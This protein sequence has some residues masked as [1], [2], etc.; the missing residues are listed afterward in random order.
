MKWTGPQ[1]FL[2]FLLA[3]TFTASTVAAN[4]LVS[5]TTGGA[6]IG[7]AACADTYFVTQ[8]LNAQ[9]NTNLYLKDGQLGGTAAP[10]AY[11]P[12]ASLRLTELGLDLLKGNGTYHRPQANS[13]LDFR[14][15]LYAGS[16]ADALK[17]Y[18]TDAIREFT[19][20]IGKLLN[21]EE[22]FRQ[23]LKV[24]P[25]WDQALDGLMETYYARAEGFMLIGNDFLARAY[26]HKFERKS[27]ES[28][29]TTEL[30]IQDIDNALQ[31]Y[32][33]GFR[34]FMKLFNP[35]YIG[36]D[37]LPRS[38]LQINAE[39]LLFSKRFPRQ[40]SSDLVSYAAL[41]G[42]ETEI[43]VTTELYDPHGQV[44]SPV[45]GSPSLAFEESQ[46]K[47]IVAIQAPVVFTLPKYE[48]M[49]SSGPG[50]SFVLR[51][52]MDVAT[53]HS[54]KDLELL[55]EF[56]NETL[57]PPSAFSDFSF[58]NSHLSLIPGT[59]VFYG[60]SSI[61][62][63]KQLFANQ[64]LL[65]FSIVT[66]A[67]G[68][69]IRVVSVPFT[70]RADASR[71]TEV[72]VYVAGSG[73]QLV[74]GFK[75]IALLYRI[76]AAYGDALGEKVRRMYDIASPQQAIKALEDAIYRINQWFEL[77]Q[78]M[79]E[80]ASSQA[81][82]A[83]NDRL[84]NAIA[85]VSSE[86]NE[87]GALREFIRS[88]ANAFGYPDDYVPFFNDDSSGTISALRNLI[89]GPGSFTPGSAT[90]FFGTARDAETSSIRSYGQLQDTK[91]RIRNELFTINEQAESRLLQICGRIDE[92]TLDPSMDSSDPIDVD[93]RA[94]GKNIASEFGQHVLLFQRA[95]SALEQANA[96]MDRLLADIELEK[97]FLA[98]ALH[99]HAEKV[100]VMNEYSVL[101]QNLD[102]E[103]GKINAKQARL[104]AVTQAAQTM[105]AG[106]NGFSAITGGTHAATV[107][108]A[109]ALANGMEQAR[110]EER[111]GELQADKTR[112]AA[113]E[114]IK[115]IKSDT[116]IFELQQVKT[117][118][119]LA[120]QLVLKA[121][122]AEM[123]ELDLQVALGRMNQLM[124]ERDELL[125]RRGRAITN[126]GEMSFAD[127]SFRLIQFSVMKDAED[128]VE[129][130]KR[131]LYLLTRTVYYEWA[132]ADDTKLRVAGLPDISINDIRRLQVIGAVNEGSGVAALEDSLTVTDYLQTLLAFHDSGPLRYSKSP[133]TINRTNSSNTARYS[134]REDFLRIVRE[135]NTL[136]ENQR[137]WKEFSAWLADPAR[138]DADGNLVIE[139][140]TMGHLENHNLP[141]DINH[142]SWTHYA[143]R[144]YSTSPLWNHKITQV[145]VSLQPRG[146]AFVSGVLNVT[147]SLQYGGVGYLKQ[148]SDSCSDF[149]AYQMR[150]WRDKGNGR[151]EPIDYRTIP[152]SIPDSS[153]FELNEAAYLVNSLKERP[154]AA[155]S[156]RLV[157]P[158]S[159]A[160]KIVL[161]NIQDIFIYINSE[162]YQR[163]SNSTQTCL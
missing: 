135:E 99:L 117:I 159:K 56:D 149:R 27:N 95:Q 86:L 31:A 129:F 84:Q 120:N 35:T 123:A 140:D 62:D 93:M 124:V 133:V 114:R 96:D 11:F 21:A 60:P 23:A 144:S 33:T 28:K 13:A 42:Q 91:D 18:Y 8:P 80:K 94:S 73:G 113:E 157:I 1:L 45:Q 148:D 75:D 116:K 97:R 90:G 82:I 36:V 155:S 139:F 54:V 132:L 15:V 108:A 89:V 105:A 102:L 26:R 5:C 146:L 101:Q 57:I 58:R 163:Q 38:F 14:R 39:D 85:S 100:Q 151:L 161:S 130:L 65:K 136:E 156:W 43:G 107:G 63:G 119:Q 121:L 20:D 98:D 88:G 12:H 9:L 48:G 87:L 24:N 19:N 71:I 70:I 74:S 152:L 109:I 110:Y 72:N 16:G 126:L 22:Y 78:S 37:D 67:T 25:Y 158:A 46:S 118:E 40:G 104:R 111:K 2:T 160:N 68:S 17:A 7:E 41:R 4:Q 34:E 51:F 145:G 44:V 162:A 134:L 32:E 69:G 106:T 50:T 10:L 153:S 79:L 81:E 66:P 138:R 52:E 143:L 77:T 61:Y 103:I 131:W 6:S 76:A 92:T 122:S 30:E 141:V 150:Q 83:N 128:Q 55:I 3:V 137:V 127:P 142:N 154:V 125:A 59:E 112:Y 47:Q 53:G 115:L 29:S 64:M 147:G 49:P